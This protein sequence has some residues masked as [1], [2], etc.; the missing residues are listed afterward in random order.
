MYFLRSGIPFVRFLIVFMAGIFVGIFYSVEPPVSLLFSSIIVYIL[1][2]YLEK[3]DFYLTFFKS[4]FAFFILFLMGVILINARTEKYESDHYT[5]LLDSIEC[6][7]ARIVS[8]PEYTDKTIKITLELKDIKVRHSCWQSTCGKMLA[9][10]QKDSAVHFKKGAV[11][12]IHGKPSPLPLTANPA[13]FN[14]SNYLA[15][16]NIYAVHF[17]RKNEFAEIGY[18]KDFFVIK[19]ADDFRAFCEE[20]LKLG[21]KGENE[22]RMASALILGVRAGLDEKLYEAYS[23]TGTVHALAVSGLHVSL[24]YFIVVTLFGFIKKIKYGKLIFAALSICIFWFYALVTGFSPSVVRAVAMFSVFLIAGIL[25]RNSGIYNTLGFSAFVILCFEPFWLLD[26]GF[27]FSFLAVVGIAYIYPILYSWLETKNKIGNKLWSLVCVSL[28]AQI[29]VSPLS[30]YYF[31]SFPLLFLPFNM[32]IVPLSSLALYTGLGGLMVY[33]LKFLA[34]FLFLVT[35]YIVRFMNYFVQ[36]PS[37]SEFLKADFL[38]LNPIELILIYLF[39][40]F[41]FFAFKNK[42]YKSFVYSSWFLFFFILSTF[43]NSILKNKK[44]TF[45]LYNVKDKTVVSLIH[46]GHAIVLSD[47]VLSNKSKVFRY[48]IYNHLAEERIRSNSFVAFNNINVFAT[49]NCSFGQLFVW[50]G[51]KILRIEKGIGEEL[52]ADFLKEISILIVS[53]TEFYKE[54]KKTKMCLKP[55]VLIDSSVKGKFAEEDTIDFYDVRR[56]G[57]YVYEF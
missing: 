28:A 5:N 39:I 49:H 55:I 14:Y 38:Y 56:Q 4:V 44:D 8:A 40:T 19:I 11:L 25:K 13:Q 36:L 2:C 17:I 23:A 3:K 51:M 57:A 1:F 10:I 35:E 18:E 7:K 42:R 24:I 6:Y 9:Y 50:Q 48:N 34:D 43:Y 33:K 20:K 29:A 53:S 15:R 41:F 54:L 27:Q 31:H 16:Q 52:S 12:L 45:T 37:G 47:S 22:Y 30:I 46:D 26:I 32:L 21:I